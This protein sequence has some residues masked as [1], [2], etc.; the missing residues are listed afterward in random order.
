MKAKMKAKSMRR[1]ATKLKAK[2][3][4]A[5]ANI[6]LQ[7]VR[8][9]ANCR[10]HTNLYKDGLLAGYMMP[11]TSLYSAAKENWNYVQVHAS[12]CASFYSGTRDG[13]LATV[14]RRLSATARGVS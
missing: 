1:E 6:K 10:G 4:L 7:Y 5:S 8:P 12:S 3:A 9:K 14:A 2:H 11:N 13:L